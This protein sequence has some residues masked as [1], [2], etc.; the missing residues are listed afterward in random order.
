MPYVVM[1]AAERSKVGESVGPCICSLDYVV[2]IVGWFTA[3]SLVLSVVG[4]TPDQPL[5]EPLVPLEAFL[6]PILPVHS[7]EMFSSLK[8]Q[9]GIL[10]AEPLGLLGLGGSGDVYFRHF[11]VKSSSSTYQQHPVEKVTCKS[12]NLN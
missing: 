2:R 5:A 12:F 10:A 8:I 4:D 9:V 6:H 11:F 3:Y 1:I 7:G